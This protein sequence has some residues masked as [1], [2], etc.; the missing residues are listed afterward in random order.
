MTSSVFD[1]ESESSGSVAC[2]DSNTLSSLRS[3]SSSIGAFDTS[4]DSRHTLVSG[5][6]IGT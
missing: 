1:G 5:S 3:F 4:F 6:S 2:D